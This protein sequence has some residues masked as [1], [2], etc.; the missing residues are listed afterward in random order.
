MFFSFKF[1]A[2]TLFSLLDKLLQVDAASAPL[3][4]RIVMIAIYMADNGWKKEGDAESASFATEI[5]A[6]A[7][8]VLF[9]TMSVIIRNTAVKISIHKKEKFL[10]RH[11]P[12]IAVFVVWLQKQQEDG[13]RPRVFVFREEFRTSI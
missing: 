9:W 5:S 10:L 6:L 4:F 7:W 8:S 2:F 3:I 13:Y 11:M 1:A 12:T